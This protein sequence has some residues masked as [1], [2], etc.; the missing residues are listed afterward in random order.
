MKT[1]REDL[2]SCHY[3]GYTMDATSDPVGDATPSKGDITLCLNCG[4]AHVLHEMW[5]PITDAEFKGL[6][7]GVKHEIGRIEA[8]RRK[9]V[10]HDLAADR[11]GE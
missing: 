5:E 10:T 3:C 6:P 1:S 9:V 8:A 11:K 4:G 2:W 7:D